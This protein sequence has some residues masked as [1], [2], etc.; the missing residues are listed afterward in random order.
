MIDFVGS[1]R[2]ARA[3]RRGDAVDARAE[4]QHRRDRLVG[5]PRHRAAPAGVGG[6]DHARLGVGEQDRGA[7]GGDDAEDQ[8]G[9]GGDERVG[10]GAL[11]VGR[12]PR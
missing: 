11:V 2:N 4:R 1:A 5:D 8:P 9:R 12:R 6:G 7:V 3:D 10:V